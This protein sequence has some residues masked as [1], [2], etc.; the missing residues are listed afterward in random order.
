MANKPTACRSRLS[1][2]FA[3][4]TATLQALRSPAEDEA[5]GLLVL[6]RRR[7]QVDTARTRSEQGAAGMGTAEQTEPDESLTTFGVVAERYKKDELPGKAPATQVEYTRALKELLP[8]FGQGQARVDPPQARPYLS[9][10]SHQEDLRQP[11]DRCALG[12]IQPGARVGLYPGCEPVRRRAAERGTRNAAGTG[13]SPTRSIG[14]S[15]RPL[16]PC[17][18]MRWRS[19]LHRSARLGRAQD[20]A[21]GHPGRSAMDQAG[22]DLEDAEDRRRGRT[23]AHNRGNH[24]AGRRRDLSPNERKGSA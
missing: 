8:V 23:A 7:Q 20:P 9:R 12:D 6:L 19:L 2:T 14:S 17:C 11:G 4:V 10:P 3:D 5:K 22:E 16:M 24:C 18:A 13:T 1:I 15:T 21:H